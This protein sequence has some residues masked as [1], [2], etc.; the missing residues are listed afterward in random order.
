MSDPSKMNPRSIE[1]LKRVMA[2]LRHPATGCPWDLQQN[3]STIAPYTIE[4]AYE[5]ADAI[6]KNDMAALKDELGDLLLQ[7]IYHAQMAAEDGAFTFDDVIEAVVT[8]MIRRHP[9]VFG[10]DAAKTAG[11]AEGFWEANKAKEREGQPKL[12]LLAS[13]PMTLPG[14]TRAQKLT[15]K[16]AK[17]GFDWPHVNFV[18]DKLTEEIAE[19]K[20][21][22]KEHQ[23]EELGDILFVLANLAR[24]LGIDPETAVRSANAK[25]ERRFS[26]IET[27]LAAKGRDWK[28]S[29]L[30][31]MDALWDEAKAIERKI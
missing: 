20:S 31:E 21:A 19:L 22:D 1:T 28:D 17:V 10:D 12:G 24:H 7:P 26:H 15:A 8:K 16:A 6:E 23:A 9:H 18:Y 5:V 4:E 11:V 29:N 14:L 27:T 25:F 13:V 2:A 3:F 30:E